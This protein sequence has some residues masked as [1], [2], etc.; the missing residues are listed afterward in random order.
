M[1]TVKS[2]RDVVE[3]CADSNP[4]LWR[5]F[6]VICERPF[7]AVSQHW[8]EQDVCSLLIQYGKAGRSIHLQQMR[9]ITTNDA[10]R[11]EEH[12]DQDRIVKFGSRDI[13]RR[14]ATPSNIMAV[15]EA[16]HTKISGDSSSGA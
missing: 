11:T 10:G 16:S 5:L 9:E 13:S 12:I 2:G 4:V 8:T 14:D 1:N 6:C 15:G 3:P 7:D